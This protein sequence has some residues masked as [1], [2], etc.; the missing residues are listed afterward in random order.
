MVH[1][2]NQ[3]FRVEI[4][5]SSELIEKLVGLSDIDHVLSAEVVLVPSLL[6]ILLN[7]VLAFL[8][9]HSSELLEDC[10]AHTECLL[11]REHLDTVGAVLGVLIQKILEELIIL[12]SVQLVLSKVGTASHVLLDLFLHFDLIQ[13]I[14]QLNSFLLLG[15]DLLHLFLVLLG[16]VLWTLEVLVMLLLVVI[17]V[18]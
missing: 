9:L 16:L 2:Y 8:W 11:L 13:S 14:L 10:S 15:F 6:E 1:L 4:D 7:V 5:S 3:R 18:H 12:G 17:L